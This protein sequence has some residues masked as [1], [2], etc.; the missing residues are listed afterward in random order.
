MEE[1]TVKVPLPMTTALEKLQLKESLPD[2]EV[3]SCSEKTPMHLRY[4]F[5]EFPFYCSECNGQVFP[6]ALSISNE[7]A[8][9]IVRWVAVYSSLFQLWVDSGEYESF[10]AS[11]LKDPKGQVNIEGLRIA[12]EVRKQRM[13]YYLWFREQDDLD[14]SNYDDNFRVK[15]PSECPVCH[16]A[17]KEHHRYP[18]GL[19]DAC[20]IS[21]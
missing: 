12:E 14:V 11:A 20:G 7:L 5:S 18:L 21:I 6:S 17:L 9:K 1:E 10:A 8:D 3:C 15:I 2:D 4:S 19:C 13:T 16:G